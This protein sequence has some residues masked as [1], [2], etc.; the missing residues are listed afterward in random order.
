M[1]KDIIP[2]FTFIFFTILKRKMSFLTKILQQKDIC[3]T[4]TV[5]VRMNESKTRDKAHEE[6]NV[7]WY[8]HVK[9]MLCGNQSIDL[10]SKLIGWFLYGSGF[11]WGYFRADYSIVLISETA[12]AK[13]PF[14]FHNCGDFILVVF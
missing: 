3:F 1:Y 9:L 14:V 13:Y 5:L 6:I 10:Q 8:I 4:L 12:I 7:Y 2:L 11:C